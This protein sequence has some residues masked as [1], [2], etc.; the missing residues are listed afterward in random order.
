MFHHYLLFSSRSG[1]RTDVPS[2]RS[3]RRP[4]MSSVL[5]APCCLHTVCPSSHQRRRLQ[6]Q[7]GIAYVHFM[8]MTPVGR[9]LVC[10]GFHSSN[11]RQPWV[12]SRPWPSLCPSAVWEQ[13]PL[14]IRWASLTGCH[15]TGL[16]FN[17]T[18]TNPHSPG[19]SQRPSLAP[20]MSPALPSSAAPRI[21]M[22]GEGA[23]SLLCAA[24]HWSTRFLWVS[25]NNDERS[26]CV[27]Y[28]FNPA[29]LNRGNDYSG[30]EIRHEK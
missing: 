10:P 18:C 21:A 8:P 14:Q 5:P 20:L 26:L 11:Y 15:L 13:V 25:P 6:R 28:S 24:K 3:A 4:P 12:G 19:W 23:A 30:S 9:Q 1:S 22:C 17:P 7:W 2:G 29:I 27:F 16:A